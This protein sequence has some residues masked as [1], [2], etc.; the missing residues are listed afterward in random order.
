MIEKADKIDQ[1]DTHTSYY[2]RSIAHQPKKALFS[3]VIPERYV[4]NI[5]I[6]DCESDHYRLLFDHNEAK[7]TF[8]MFELSFDAKAKRMHFYTTSS[9][10][11]RNNASIPQ[12]GLKD[13][14]LIGL[15]RGNVV[16]LWSA[17]KHGEELQ[18]ITNIEEGEDWHLD[19]LNSKIRLISSQKG[20][21][22]MKSFEW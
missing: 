20:S 10:K 2:Y 9:A 16:E 11:I 3:K 19:V 5:V 22:L 15:D 17:R 7:I 1:Y 21:F 12:R 13:K 18:K 14:L 6:I 4:A 8:F